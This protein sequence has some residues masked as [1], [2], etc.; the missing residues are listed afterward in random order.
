MK[1]ALQKRI[2]KIM[3]HAFVQR[4][5][6]GGESYGWFR[7]GLGGSGSLPSSLPRPRRLLRW[8]G[9]VLDL[10]RRIIV[11]R[12]VLLVVLALLLTPF[13]LKSPLV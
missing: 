10:S 11:A 5:V 4:L 12:P 9:L 2:K 7:V 8:K 1:K 13:D 3:R 6:R